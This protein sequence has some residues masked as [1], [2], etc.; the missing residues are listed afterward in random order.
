MFKFWRRNKADR[1]PAKFDLA[2]IKKTVRDT[3]SVVLSERHKTNIVDQLTSNTID[4]VGVIDHNQYQDGSGW[5]CF[6]RGIPA[7]NIINTDPITKNAVCV[8][9]NNLFD[10]TINYYSKDGR[11]YT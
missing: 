7:S 8:S 6:N 3:K 10:R 2:E 11:L 9:K 5:V 1:T 4:D